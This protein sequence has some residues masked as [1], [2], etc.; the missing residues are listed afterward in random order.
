[1]GAF[2][3]SLQYYQPYITLWYAE[4]IIIKGIQYAKLK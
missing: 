1:M 4:H 2:V 3:T